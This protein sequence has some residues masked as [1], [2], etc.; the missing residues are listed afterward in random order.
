MDRTLKL[1]MEYLLVDREQ[2]VVVEPGTKSIGTSNEDWMKLDEKARSKIRLCLA[3]SVLL[4]VSEE[5]MMKK[6]LD[7]LGN[8]YQ[9]KSMVN[10]LFLQKKLYLLRMNDDD[11]VTKH[12]NAFNTIISQLL[13]VDIKET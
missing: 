13:S 9:S 12:L 6:L 5:D 10:N 1:K 11:L 7:K 2:Q 3:G 4:N 8:L